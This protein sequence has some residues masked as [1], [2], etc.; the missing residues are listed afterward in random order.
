M[1]IE[2]DK[3]T[4]ASPIIEAE[5]G[6]ASFIAKIPRISDLVPPESRTGAIPVFSVSDES[7]KTFLDRN[8]LKG[9]K[10]AVEVSFVRTVTNGV[11]SYGFDNFYADCI[12]RL[13]VSAPSIL[14]NNAPLNTMSVANFIMKALHGNALSTPFA[15]DIPVQV[16][17]ISREDTT[18]R[19]YTIVD[20]QARVKIF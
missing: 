5:S 12:F 1:A 19:F 20:L 17:S 7:A 14:S 11:I 6:L 13:G 8:I 4:Y 9:L 16:L 10:Q 2:D 15:G 18:E 3:K